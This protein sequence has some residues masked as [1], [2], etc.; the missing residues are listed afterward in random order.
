MTN[1]VDDV[2]AG[3]AAAL[4]AAAIAQ[5]GLDDANRQILAADERGAAWAERAELYER[6]AT[7]ARQRADA[8]KRVAQLAAEMAGIERFRENARARFRS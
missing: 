7:L 4:E 2:R 6:E 8:C 5:H 1:L 3:L